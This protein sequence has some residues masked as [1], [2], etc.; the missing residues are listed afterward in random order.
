MSG[1]TVVQMLNQGFSR[2]YEVERVL[3][4]GGPFW[5]PFWANKKVQNTKQDEYYSE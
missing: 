2:L 1:T 5:V 4:G 3:S